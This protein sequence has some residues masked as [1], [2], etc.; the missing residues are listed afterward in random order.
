MSIHRLLMCLFSAFCG[1][2]ALNGNVKHF[3]FDLT[4]DVTG[5]PEVKFYNFIWKISS[6]PL[7]WCLIFSAMSIGYRD[8]WGEALRPPPPPPPQQR[9]GVGL[10]P[11]G[12]GLSGAGSSVDKRWLPPAGIPVE[13]GRRALCWKLLLNYLPPSRLAWDEALHRQRD[14]YRRFICE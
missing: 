6:R 12:R 4:C 13:K 11:A 1:G 7:Y 3:V 10:G 14:A 9:A 2:K 5:D 8:R